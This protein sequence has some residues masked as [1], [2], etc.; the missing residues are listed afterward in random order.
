MK[1]RVGIESSVSELTMVKGQYEVYLE[2]HLGVP[3]R[4]T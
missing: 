1:R 4:N 2:K 3:N